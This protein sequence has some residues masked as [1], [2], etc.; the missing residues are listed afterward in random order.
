M[1][2]DRSNRRVFSGRIHR[3]S[4]DAAARDNTVQSSQR[5][6][7]RTTEN[8]RSSNGTSSILP[9]S[10]AEPCP[11]YPNPTGL[12]P[13]ESQTSQDVSHSI[14]DIGT[15]TTAGIEQ[16]QSNQAS[17]TNVHSV[18][19]VRLTTSTNETRSTQLASSRG[20]TSAAM[21]NRSTVS[22]GS[23]IGFHDEQY[24]AANQ[25]RTNNANTDVI[26]LTRQS[27]HHHVHVDLN[28]NIDSQGLMTSPAE[29]DNVFYS[30]LQHHGTRATLD[31]Q[32]EI[33]VHT[34]SEINLTHSVNYNAFPL[35]NSSSDNYPPLPV[36]DAV[37]GYSI[38]ELP[39]LTESS[40]HYPAG[41]MM[42]PRQHRAAPG[43]DCMSHDLYHGGDRHAM[44][45]LAP[46]PE[47]FYI[48]PVRTTRRDRRH[49]ERRRR[50]RRSR[51]HHHHHRHRSHRHHHH[52]VLEDDAYIKPC[53]SSLG[54][55]ICLSLCLQFKK[56]LVFFASFGIICVLL[57]IVLGVLRAPGNSFFTLSLMFV[58]KL[59]SSGLPHLPHPFGLC[60]EAAPCRVKF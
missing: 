56:V 35:T 7:T 11:D 57:G 17:H 24:I 51:H 19:P 37:S 6:M 27:S 12:P 16:A 60:Y 23:C 41:A 22:P 54:C 42:S 32:V 58:G 34:N 28:A 5:A 9:R 50:R 29:H 8:A 20:P 39:R 38:T 44:E 40:L 1:A 47:P 25:Q 2:R 18:Y 48:P 43:T 53:C 26:D 14:V 59:H 30:N 21:E 4:R 10:I 3:R 36:P 15:T 46:G 31:T 52:Q 45:C 55:K 49:R 13:A 33:N